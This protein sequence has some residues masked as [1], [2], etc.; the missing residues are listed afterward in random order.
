M[1]TLQG[2]MA[3]V[4]IHVADLCHAKQ[5][6]DADMHSPNDMLVD[7]EE[8]VIGPPENEKDELA[9]INPDELN[10]EDTELSPGLPL[11]DDCASLQ[12]TTHG[13]PRC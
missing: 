2:K 9:V 13:A 12:I 8:Y 10:N 4:Q 7:P 1:A 3:N 11:A 5:G 6:L